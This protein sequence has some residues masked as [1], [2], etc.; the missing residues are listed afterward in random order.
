MVHISWGLLWDLICKYLEQYLVQSKLYI[1]I[2]CYAREP[3]KISNGSKNP[4]IRIWN[5]GSNPVGHT[6]EGPQDQ[7]EEKFIL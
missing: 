3:R 5:V 2:C 6:K 4:D 7:Q 1:S